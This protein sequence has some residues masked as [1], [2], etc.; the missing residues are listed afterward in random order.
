[1]S[2]EVAEIGVDLSEKK[3]SEHVENVN[4]DLESEKE[5]AAAEAVDPV[6]GRALI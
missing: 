4:H 2:D 1:L 5:V 3:T 6:S